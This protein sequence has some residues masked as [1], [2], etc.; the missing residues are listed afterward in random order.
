MEIGEILRELRLERKMSQ[1][2]L[3]KLLYTTQDTISLWELGKS[4]PSIDSL[5]I[6]AVIFDVTTDELLDMDNFRLYYKD[7]YK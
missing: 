3:A 4:K 6:I 2:E 1:T 7:R 5:K